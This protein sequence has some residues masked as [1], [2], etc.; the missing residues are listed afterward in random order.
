VL[1]VRA[2]CAMDDKSPHYGHM[3]TRHVY[4]V[5]SVHSVHSVHTVHTVPSD[6]SGCGRG[7]WR[8]EGG[9]GSLSTGCMRRSALRGAPTGSS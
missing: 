9:S 1:R 2:T 8:W 5:R 7:G 4:S 6:R 3:A